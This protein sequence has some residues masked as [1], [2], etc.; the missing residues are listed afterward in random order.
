MSSTITTWS[1]EAHTVP[2]LL[3]SNLAPPR[4]PSTPPRPC[5]H[6]RVEH[7]LW[8]GLTLTLTLTLTL[9]TTHE[10]SIGYGDCG[11][12][13]CCPEPHAS[14]LSQ[15][16]CQT[17]AHPGP[18]SP[19]CSVPSAHI[20]SCY[21]C[22]PLRCCFPPLCVCACGAGGRLATIHG[23]LLRPWNGSGRPRRTRCQ[24]MIEHMSIDHIISPMHV[25]AHDSAC[26]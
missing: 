11:S 6:P 3:I 21:V 1:S 18:R 12:H 4:P 9:I 17:E 15:A 19:V 5:Y 8:R 2:L 22:G 26:A 23:R 25:N 14:G 16:A 24:A 20:Q 10:S 7:R 13:S